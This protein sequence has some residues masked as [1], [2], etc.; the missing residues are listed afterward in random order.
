M[1]AQV[2]FL[3]NL[4]IRLPVLW[5]SKNQSLGSLVFSAAFFL[6][7]LFTSVL[8]CVFPAALALKSVC[9]SLFSTIGCRERRESHPVLAWDVINAPVRRHSSCRILEVGFSK[10]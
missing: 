3:V 10:F 5:L 1:C 6:S 4:A 9:A 2:L 7:V 8:I